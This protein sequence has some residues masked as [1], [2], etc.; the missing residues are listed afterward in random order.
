MDDTT[1]DDFYKDAEMS[2]IE[3]FTV[4]K[5]KMKNKQPIET[6]KQEMM[7]NF[8]EEWCDTFGFESL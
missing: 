4:T 5:Y 6:A 1:L 7:K 2:F 8:I 3:V